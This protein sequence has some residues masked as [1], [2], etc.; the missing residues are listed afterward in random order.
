MQQGAPRG[1]L[2]LQHLRWSVSSYPANRVCQLTTSFTEHGNPTLVF[3]NDCAFKTKLENVA[4]DH[5]ED[6]PGHFLSL[7][8]NRNAPYLGGETGTSGDSED[9]EEE[10]NIGELA[11]H[12][13][14]LSERMDSI[15]ARI[16]TL[17]ELMQT[18]FAV[19]A[20]LA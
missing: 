17:V 14:K 12:V 18:T 15:D 2:H 3:C 13:T 16:N 9:E 4:P 11:K 10:H 6:I 8:R 20:G 5:I 1:V 19:R 7:I